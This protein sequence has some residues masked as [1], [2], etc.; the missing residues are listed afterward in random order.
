[1][2]EARLGQASAARADLETALRINPY[3]SVLWSPV[4]R[5]TLASLMDVPSPLV[6]EGQGGG[7]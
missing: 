1:M 3:F 7:S 4:A 6:G 5:Q 2:I